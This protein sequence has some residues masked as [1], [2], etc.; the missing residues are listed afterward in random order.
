MQIKTTSNKMKEKK[1]KKKKKKDN[2]LIFE[3]LQAPMVWF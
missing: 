1:S 2:P 3:E